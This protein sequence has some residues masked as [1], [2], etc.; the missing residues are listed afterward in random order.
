MRVPA[1]HR[2]TRVDVAMGF[3]WWVARPHGHKGRLVAMKTRRDL[4]V[5]MLEKIRIMSG[6]CWVW[7]G[8]RTSAGYGQITIKGRPIP[9][10]RFVY[11]MLV[12]PIPRGLVLDHICRNTSCLNPDHLEPVTVGENLRRGFGV[13]AVN[14]KKTHCIRGHAFTPDNT[15]VTS[16]QRRCITCSRARHAEY[17]ARKKAAKP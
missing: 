7:W 8:G 15:L 13:M 11:E 2:R 1:L 16:H 6:P 12:G 5:R 10:H 3:S 4:P 17:R 9:A 14:A